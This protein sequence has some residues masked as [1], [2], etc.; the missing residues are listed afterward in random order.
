MFYTEKEQL[1]ACHRHVSSGANVEW[2]INSEFLGLSAHGQSVL[3]LY[4]LAE[5]VHYL[6]YN[7]NCFSLA[8]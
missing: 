5:Y 2:S 1:V 7:C 8:Q 3:T 6:P 4:K